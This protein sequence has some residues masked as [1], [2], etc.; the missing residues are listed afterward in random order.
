MAGQLEGS[1]RNFSQDS[2]FSLL[3]NGFFLLRLADFQVFKNDTR[4]GV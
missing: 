3:K 4:T 1:N 2:S